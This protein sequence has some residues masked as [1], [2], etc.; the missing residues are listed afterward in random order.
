MAIKSCL[1]S[2]SQMLFP[3]PPSAPKYTLQSTFYTQLSSASQISENPMINTEM[4]PSFMNLQSSRK[5]RHQTCDYQ[6]NVW[7]R[8]MEVYRGLEKAQL[9]EPIWPGRLPQESQS[10][11]IPWRLQGKPR[12]QAQ[13]SSTGIS[14]RL[15]TSCLQ[16]RFR[17]KAFCGHYT[18]V[19]KLKCA[20]SLSL[21]SKNLERFL[22]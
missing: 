14:P 9:G 12:L 8:R 19:K 13:V 2:L 15:H 4:V 11:S 16:D 3:C 7:K 17:L 21:E 18:V 1:L 10:Q 20:P 5:E 22:V 6:E